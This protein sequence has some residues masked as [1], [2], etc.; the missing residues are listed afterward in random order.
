MRNFHIKSLILGIGIGAVVVSFIGII[1]SA[2][3]KTEMSKEEIIL[4]AKQ[5]GLVENKGIINENND[6]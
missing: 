6:Y 5:Y 3:M 1:Y 2:G 4:R